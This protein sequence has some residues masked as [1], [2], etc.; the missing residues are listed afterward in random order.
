[1]DFE[2]RIYAHAKRVSD[3]KDVAEREEAA[4]TALILSFFESNGL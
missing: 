1:M 2:D 4:K 3:L